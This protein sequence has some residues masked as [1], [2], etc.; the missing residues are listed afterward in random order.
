MDEKAFQASAFSL[1]FDNLNIISSYQREIIEHEAKQMTSLAVE[2]WMELK[3][4]GHLTSPVLKPSPNP[5]IIDDQFLRRLF[6]K[7]N[8]NDSSV[9][10][11]KQSNKDLLDFKKEKTDQSNDRANKLQKRFEDIL[12]KADAAEQAHAKQRYELSLEL[13]AKLKQARERRSQI[14][15]EISSAAAEKTAFIDKLLEAEGVDP[16]ILEL[17]NAK[18]VEFIKQIRRE[19]AEKWRRIAEEQEALQLKKAQCVAEILHKQEIQREETFR[20]KMELV[21]KNRENFQRALKERSEYTKK[22]REIAADKAKS[23]LGK[24]EDEFSK[25]VQDIKARST[26]KGRFV[27]EVIEKKIKNAIPL[28]DYEARMHARYA[29]FSKNADRLAKAKARQELMILEKVRVISEK[30]NNIRQTR[31][32]ARSQRQDN[33]RLRALNRSKIEVLFNKAKIGSDNKLLEEK[34]EKVVSVPC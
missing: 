11:Q 12:A 29:A 31:Q 13:K 16:E 21:R 26:E 7:K 2:R 17:S 23:C 22:K 9:S 14:V 18:K 20:T 27:Q 3:N 25:E 30:Q 6:Q 34:I 5:G 32:M 15:H 4:M 28:E 8:F 19:K 33:F 10:L 24:I 1:G